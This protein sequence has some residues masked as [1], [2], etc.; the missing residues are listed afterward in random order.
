MKIIPRMDVLSDNSVAFD[1][2]L[3]DDDGGDIVIPLDLL[4]VD[5]ALQSAAKLHKVLEEITGE[6]IKKMPMETLTTGW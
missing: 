2:W 5:L 6:Q 1:L 4:Q 3:V